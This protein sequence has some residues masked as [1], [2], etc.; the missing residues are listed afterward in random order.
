M[1]KTW[2]RQAAVGLMI[3]GL[4]LPGPAEAAIGDQQN[5]IE[6]Q[7]GAPDLV[8][9]QERKIWTAQEWQ[10]KAHADAASYGYL[11]PEG[12]SAA[13]RW[14]TYNQ[15]GQVVKELVLLREPIR[16]R[17]FQRTFAEQYG[18]AAAVESVSVAEPFLHAE[19]LGVIV[20]AAAGGR[21]HIRLLIQADGTELNMHSKLSG[22][23]VTPISTKELQEKLAGKVW[24]KTDNYFQAKLYFSETLTPRKRTDEIVIHHTAIEAMS[25][26]DIHVL[27]LTNGW[28]G[29]GYHKV[30]LPDG[31]IEP[32]RP[33][34]MVGAH[35]FG[36]NRRSI[37]IAVVG[38]FELRPPSEAQLVSLVQ[39]TRELM[40]KYN[41]S[42]A[43]V[44]PHRQVTAG[45]TC[46]GAQFPWNEF[47]ERVKTAK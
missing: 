4:L 29:I 26:A 11:L 41:V 22:F 1:G 25:V 36:A 16:V 40:K 37:G 3:W 18:N 9:D 31:S 45:T 2:L 14:L 34:T 35:A 27:H 28:A 47:S 23:E 24:R 42:A 20:S 7:Y 38:N 21:Q 13:S 6:A 15:Q 19:Q 39:L 10:Q 46:P 33:E 12:E 17:D 30:I 32:G 8:Q 43:N 5:A 44:L